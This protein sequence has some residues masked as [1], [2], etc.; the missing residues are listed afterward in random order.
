MSKINSYVFFFLLAYD[1]KML[2]NFNVTK[3]LIK[4]QNI[5][6]SKLIFMLHQNTTFIYPII[7]WLIKEN[8]VPI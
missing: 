8:L 7:L 2:T 1:V 4:Y 6:F 5:F 3:F